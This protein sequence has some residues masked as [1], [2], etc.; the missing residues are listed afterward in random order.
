MKS[1]SNSNSHHAL[2][3]VLVARHQAVHPKVQ[4]LNVLSERGRVHRYARQAL[5]IV[6]VR[7]KNISVT[8]RG[9]GL[10]ARLFDDFKLSHS[11]GLLPAVWISEMLHRLADMPLDFLL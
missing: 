1:N 4:I 6:R 9:R 2:E 8:R 10:E 7:S 11:G 5:E 3:A